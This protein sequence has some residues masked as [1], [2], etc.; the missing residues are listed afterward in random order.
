[1]NLKNG[2][3]CL[4]ISTIKN[5]KRVIF[6]FLIFCLLFTA[7]AF[8]IGMIQIVNSDK[9][10][11]LALEQQI[12]DIPIVPKR[13]I[14]YDRNGK[15]LAVN[16][17]SSTIWARPGEIKKSGKINEI[18]QTLSQILGIDK[19]KI[20]ETLKEKRSLVRV[21]KYIEKPAADKIR[22][23]DLSGISVADDTKRYY[24]FGN[25]AANVLGNTTDDNNGL[26]GIELKYNKYLKG[27]PGRMIRGTDAFGRELSYSSGK[28]Y[29]A[30]NGL[31]VVLTIDEVI[32]HFVEKALTAA[33]TETQAKRVMCIVMD[34]KTGEILA[35]ANYPN[36]DP[37]NPR[38]PLL[39]KDQQSFNTLTPQQKQD[40]WSEMWKNPLV[41]DAYEPGSTLKLITASI[42]LEEGAALP[43]STF[44]DKGYVMV[45]GVKLK[46]SHSSKP[47][48]QVTLVK[49]VQDSLNA[50]FVELGQRV[51]VDKFYDYLQSFGFTNKTGIDFPGEG[52]A[53]IYPH[54]NIGPVEFATMSYG[55]GIA[56]TPIQLI[57]AIST[58]GNEGMLMKPH[59][60]KELRDDNGNVVESFKP[61]VVRKV[62]SKDTASKM[63]SIMEAVVTGGTGE[64][65]SVP[66]YRIGGKTGTADK[67]V[68]G[69]YQAIISSFVALAPIDDPKLTVLFI[70][71]EPKG[72]HYGSITAAPYV[73]QILADSLR[74]LNI[75][76]SYIPQ[77]PNSADNV[78][79]PQV[80]GLKYKDAKAA[81]T[82]CQLSYTLNPAASATTDFTILDQFPKAGEKVRKGSMVYLYH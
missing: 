10:A 63:E 44:Y 62:L 79:M 17:I 21:T 28:N 37:N 8:R 52:H 67:A 77:P 14:I 25:F 76:P 70:V 43:Q 39:P 30:E 16:A 68:K 45:S 53:I 47:L 74:Y 35:M 60:V 49:A 29:N 36:Y 55:Q 54:D 72:A 4:A 15:E 57:T 18:S 64:K 23:A 69:T 50:V 59:I 81:L 26:S 48:G 65:A 66:G 46:N 1:M 73:Q 9:Y 22:K 34:P 40:Y 58:I 12:R 51:G 6:L 19:K 41:S 2:V 13:G 5:K 56:V 27:V 75:K 7:L 24:P 61:E 11:K 71:D 42:A 32:Q 3:F 78:V 33:Y 80:T 20:E 82:K 31:N 38:I